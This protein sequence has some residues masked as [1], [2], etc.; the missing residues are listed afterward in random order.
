MDT[1]KLKELINSRRTSQKELAE[2][3]ELSEHGIGRMIKN[4]EFKVSTLEEISKILKV[5][6][7]YWFEEKDIK[8]N[9]V[10]E[11]NSN[12]VLTNNEEMK[13]LNE[14]LQDQLKKKDGQIEFLENQL[15]KAQG[16]EPKSKASGE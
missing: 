4:G 3:L 15:L 8:E 11:E 12:Y 14:L 13:T 1:R 16:I 9:Y 5:P 6:M 7:N 10:G 2:K